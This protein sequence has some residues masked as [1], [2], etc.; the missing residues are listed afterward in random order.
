MR[1]FGSKSIICFMAIEKTLLD[2]IAIDSVSGK[3]GGVRDYVVGRLEKL[4]LETE[5]DN[6]GNLICV[7]PGTGKALFLNAHLDR[8][9]PGRGHVPVIKNGVVHSNGETNLGADDAA[10][11]TIILE[12]VERVIESKIAH[13]KL[14]LV[15]TVEEEIGLFGAKEFDPGAYGV[16]S[17]LVYDNA[18][19]A[20]VVVGSG[21]GFGLFEVE[22][23]G[24]SIHSGKDLE[25]SVN[26]FEVF[27]HLSIK[28]GEIRPG[29]RVNV[30]KVEMGKMR[31][32]V[33][34]KLVFEGEVRANMG[35]GEILALMKEIEGEFGRAVSK[36]KGAKL[37]FTSR[38]MPISYEVSANEPLVRAY[39]EVLADRGEKLTIKPTF[40]GSDANALRTYHGIKVFT[41][42][43]GVVGEHTTEE[44]VRIVDLEMLSKDL[45]DLLCKLADKNG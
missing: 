28:T 35:E 33:P 11:I 3:E 36:V 39:E 37:T 1:V 14:V 9:L 32:V 40:V 25:K 13:P 45:V 15:F 12:A 16:A 23:V 30:G 42:S 6:K 38:V 27:E 29:V 34:D 43:T 8:V 17:G 19:E 20:G 24:K 22:V 31:N 4:G 10:G 18:F 2:L 44:T 41:I 5:L 7:V 26:V 21:C